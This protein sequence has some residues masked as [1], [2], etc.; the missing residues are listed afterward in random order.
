MR[1][2]RLQQ[3]S[4]IWL[5]ILGAMNVAHAASGDNSST[6]FF[7]IFLPIIGVFAVYAFLVHSRCPKCKR[8]LTMKE[9]G[10]KEVRGQDEA[11]LLEWEC[12]N[13]GYTIWKEERVDNNA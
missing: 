8:T 9:T 1:N 13:C 2:T 10:R 3:L 7:W 4:C 5:T 6:S 12:E 11:D